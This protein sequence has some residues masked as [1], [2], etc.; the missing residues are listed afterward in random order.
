MENKVG[1]LL[2]ILG[3]DNL[4][5]EVISLLDKKEKEKLLNKFQKAETKNIQEENSILTQ[6][7][8]SLKKRNKIKEN[9][10]LAIKIQELLK[11]IKEENKKEN[12]CNIKNLKKKNNLELKKILY[13][14]KI[15]LIAL[16]L[17]FSNPVEAA[18]VLQTYPQKVKERIILEFENIDTQKVEQK[19]KLNQ[20]LKFKKEII[21]Q[22]LHS[23]KLKNQKLKEVTDILNQLNP[24]ENLTLISKIN[25]KNPKFAHKILSHCYKF[26][27]L[28]SLSNIDL[29][30][31]FKEVN[32]KLVAIFFKSIEKDF[33]KEIKKKLNTHLQK[34]INLE[35][36]CIGPISIKEIETSQR[37]ILDSLQYNVENGKINFWKELNV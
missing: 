9:P 10:E 13:G 29:N 7:N 35:I 19:E 14:E 5:N 21:N 4:P 33:E 11:T 31:L 18:K 30:F 22:N 27:D 12:F 3:S 20:F 36:S 6:F 2:R 23:Y 17:S 16:T 32:I 37:V 1:K 26:E 15:E 25:K 28:K 8:S 24:S 34:K